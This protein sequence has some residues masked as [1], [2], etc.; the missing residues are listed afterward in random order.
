MD[1]LSEGQLETIRANPIEA[2]LD[3]DRNVFRTSFPSTRTDTS[4]AHVEQLVSETRWKYQALQLIVAILLLPATSALPST[5]ASGLLFDQVSSLLFRLKS[6]DVEIAQIRH[7]VWCVIAEVDD[8]QV[9][10]ELYKVIA[11]T[12]PIRP[13]TPTRTAPAVSPSFLQTPPVHNSSSMNSSELRRNVDPALRMEF[14]DKLFIDHPEILKAFCRHVPRLDKIVDVILTKCKEMDPPLYQDGTGWREWPEG[15][16][17]AAV[18]QWLRRHM[19]LFCSLV[20]DYQLAPQTQRRCLTR[21]NQEVLGSRRKMD[22]GIAYEANG[23]VSNSQG[24]EPGADWSQILVAGELKSN[25][26]E[27]SYPRTWLDLARYAREIFYAQDRRFVL[28]FTICGSKMRIWEFDRLG[29]VASPPFDVHGDT[30][31]FIQV[32]VAFFFMTEQQLGID[33][34]IRMDNGQRV[35]EIIRDEQI[36]KIVLAK[37]IHRHHAIASRA[38]TCWRAFRHGDESK[39]ELIVKDSWQYQER[40]E[41]GLLLQEASEKGVQNISRYYY[42]E[43][44]QINSKDDDVLYNIRGGLAKASARDAFE[45]DDTIRKEVADEASQASSQMEDR[46]RSRKRSLRSYKN[47]PPAK[48]KLRSRQKSTADDKPTH[49][50]IHRRVITQ[51]AGKS[52]YEA[53][54]LS[55]FIRGLIGAINGHKSLL[56]VGILHR[57]IS[58]GNIMLTDEEDDGFLIDLDFAVKL[59]AEKASGAPSKVGTKV[60]MAIGALYGEHHSF[61]HDLESFFWVMFWICIHWD[62]PD[63]KLA[64][65]IKDRRFNEQ[66][67]NNFSPYCKPLIPCIKELRKVIFPGGEQLSREDQSLYSQIIAVLEKAITEV[68]QLKKQKGKKAISKKKDEQ[69]SGDADAAKDSSERSEAIKDDAKQL[70]QSGNPDGQS[71]TKP[72]ENVA[73]ADDGGL[74][75]SASVPA[76]DTGPSRQP[77]IS[78]QSR[79]RSSSFRKSISQPP[80]SPSNVLKSPTLPPLTPEGDTV[81]DIYRK[82][83]L[84]LDELEKENRRLKDQLNDNEELRRKA[85]HETEELREAQGDILSS[86]GLSDKFQG[87]EVDVEKLKSEIASLQRQIAHLQ[88]QSSKSRHVSSPSSH[89]ALGSP[90]SD[91]EEAL[92]SKSATIES[93]EMEIS[94]LSAKLDQQSSSTSSH[95]AQVSALE[96]QLEKSTRA[97]ETSQLQLADLKKSLDRTSE[98]AIKESSQRTSAETKLRSLE[99]TAIESA[100]TIASLKSKV[101][102]LEQKIATL[103]SLHKDSDAR[104]HARARDLASAQRDTIALKS[105]YSALEEE[106][107]VLRED[108][109]RRRKMATD[110]VEADDGVDELESEHTLLLQSRIRTLEADNTDLRR[111]VWRDRRQRLERGSTAGAAAVTGDGFDDVDLSPTTGRPSSPQGRPQGLAQVL[112]GGF[113]ALTAGVGVGV[114]VGGGGGGDSS[115]AAELDDDIDGFDEDAFRAAQ[116]EEALKRVERV[117]ELKR[118]LKAWEHWRVDLVES[119]R[120]AGGAGEVFEV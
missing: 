87:R 98:R 85:E 7:L 24:S 13:T 11:R 103:T 23:N 72:E 67:D 28:G 12:Q 113:S 26:K 20:E 31:I 91:L 100:E 63:I 16:K 64:M 68:E 32:M 75:A 116:E 53:T 86:K 59:E 56:G 76:N 83:A 60:F 42:H 81:S 45:Q 105:R 79:L 84:R 118:G 66:V 112:S 62:G 5:D 65:T 97:A 55:A 25:P 35:V 61:M 117:R 36:E 101:A 15:C 8:V 77:S 46:S 90:P 19:I 108:R 115:M 37:V 51:D 33:P 2:R 1:G 88:S 29:G 78:V 27:D 44:V 119:R 21:P 111:G 43:T 49:N 104:S 94:R 71:E 74:V 73:E 6:G 38:T 99:S 48:K 22:V 69:G 120:V 114:G 47:P 41:E 95:A 92:K 40:P 34:T 18:L 3:E 58:A 4:L 54:S 106:L 80:T 14:A 70:E 30:R 50:R 39:A 93:M 52:L 89:N 82:Q 57:D 107:S 17:E 96:A 110:G 102:A 109:D 10:T 9:W